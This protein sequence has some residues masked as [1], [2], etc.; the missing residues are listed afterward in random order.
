V[1]KVD[2]S[3]AALPDKLV[4][5][6]ECKSKII[7][8]VLENGKPAKNKKIFL[9]SSDG[10]IYPLDSADEEPLA[11]AQPLELKTDEKGS[12][13]AGIR[14]P[15]RV[16]TVHLVAGYKSGDVESLISDLEKGGEV[17]PKKNTAVGQVTLLSDEPAVLTV[18]AEPREVVADGVSLCVLVARVL[19][20]Y[21]NP[22]SGQEV[23][24]YSDLG[25]IDPER[26]NCLTDSEGK[27]E[28]SITSDKVGVATV[29]VTNQYRSWLEEILPKDR[30]RKNGLLGIL[31][32]DN[33][34]SAARGTKRVLSE[35]IQIRFIP[36]K[37]STLVLA[38]DRTRVPADGK[39]EARVSA[40]LRDE[41]GNPVEGEELVFET[42]LGEIL[43]SANCKTD[44]E[45]KAEVR[46]RSTRVG[47]ASVRARTTGDSPL[48]A[49]AE[50][51]FEPSSPARISVTAGP[52]VLV[53]DAETGAVVR[54]RV[55]DGSGNPV[56]DKKV[57]FETTLGSIAEDRSQLTDAEGT[58]EVRVISA[59]AGT[60]LVTASCEG[61]QGTVEITF[62][63]GPPA[64]IAFSLNPMVEDSWRSRLDQDYLS[65]M[66]QAA[67]ALKERKFKEAASVLEV[68][69][70]ILV[71][72][73]NYAAICNLAYAYQQAGDK[74]KAQDLYKMVI[75]VLGSGRKITVKAGS[76]KRSYVAKFPHGPESDGYEFIPIRPKDFQISA[77]V[78]DDNG[79]VITDLL[80]EFE[81]NFG[82][83]P[84]DQRKSKTNFVGAAT[85]VATVFVPE[86]F[87]ELEFAWVN[88]GQMK[89]NALD[90]E[91]A[92]QC[93]RAAISAAPDSV[94]ALESLASLLVKTGNSELAKKV[95]YNLGRAYA[96]REQLELAIQFYNR[97]IQLDASYAKALSACGAAYLKM[98]DFN[99][100]RR[101]LEESVKADRSLKAALANLGLLYY[102]TGKFEKAIQM[103]RRALK[104]DSAFKPALINLHQVYNAMGERERAA[105]YLQRA[106]SV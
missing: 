49:G 11:A 25:T 6:G 84:D 89:E 96:R 17:K 54:A 67:L 61:I 86:G 40:V 19:D 82:W 33:E 51:S 60:A 102:L 47:A 72:T 44:A 42:D 91:G 106:E 31:K 56:P 101:Y 97:A 14:L 3:I 18:E 85:S 83:I 52:Q 79:N 1:A 45:G 32:S 70:D 23:S 30:G 50:V 73:N 105:E 80:V 55:E 65:A 29:T 53:A 62:K 15:N 87:S 100:A 95:F 28:S 69:R 7:V 71:K 66:R 27:A 8:E 88:L 34:E 104:V 64:S 48:L 41:F 43:P 5:D 77:A 13:S 94:R 68:R 24:F 35:K 39:T 75:D 99:L 38:A 76:L 37:P 10:E 74:K 22:V 20:R 93:Y 26:V 98:G 46:L 16:G 92:E 4:N 57:V 58:A 59:R 36:S 90:Y 2:I 78:T 81:A 21:G 12:A 9:G 63:P 103:N